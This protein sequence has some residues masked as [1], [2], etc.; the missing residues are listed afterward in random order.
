MDNELR[1]KIKQ[2]PKESGVYLFRN[3]RGKVIYVGKAK[4]LKTRVSSYFNRNLK[5]GTKTS[6]LV[7]RIT[8]LET[9]KTSSEVEALI[10]EAELI[11]RYKPKYN[12]VQKDDKSHLYIV[13]RNDKVS[14]NGKKT[15]LPKIITARKTDLKEKDKV[16]GPFP[17]SSDTRTIL[18]TIRKGLPFRNCSKTKFNKYQ[19][20]GRPCLYGYINLCQAPCQKDADITKYR[21]EIRRIKKFL[22]G[23][24]SKLLN[25][26]R[27]KMEKA[28]K[29]TDFEKAAYYRDLIKKFEYIRS[30]F[31]TAEKYIENPN[32]V[33]DLAR[34]ATAQLKD[35]IP[36]LISNPARIECYDISDLSGKE[37]VGSMVVANNGMID[38]QEYKRFKIKFKDQP[39][40]YE[41]MREVLLRR[42]KRLK[43]S[44]QKS[45]G[46]EKPDLI[47][48]DGGKGQVSIGL[49]VMQELK[50]NIPVVGLAKKE[51]SL[52][53]KT[54][55]GFM[56]NP[57]ATDEE[58][59]KLLIRLRDEAHRFAQSYHHHLRLKK[60]NV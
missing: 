2:L 57:L 51:E 27:Q 37:A 25:Q 49:Q 33:E 60:F 15:K 36:F 38:K 20:L 48:L 34:E 40:D 46:W 17:N 44:D 3:S 54:E 5:L 16:F 59:A 31:K 8:D 14:V 50:L 29:E 32:L 28:S 13:I 41:M 55:K 35:K 12:V 42:L 18:G 24:S 1:E 23:D 10:L 21:K 6:A 58:G 52:V 19:K 47:V 7:S 26:Y 11:K 30:N 22:A 43:K 4:R 9:I 53:F 56:V 39:D 45:K